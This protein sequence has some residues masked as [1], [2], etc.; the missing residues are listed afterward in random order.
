MPLRSLA[1]GIVVLIAGCSLFSGHGGATTLDGVTLIRH[2]P[3][4][5]WPAGLLRGRVEVVD[6]CVALVGKGW[7]AFVLWPDGFD[8]RKGDGELEVAG[9]VFVIPVGST[10]EGGGGLMHLGNAQSLAGDAIP[11]PCQVKGE[12][13]AY[14]GEVASVGATSDAVAMTGRSSDLSGDHALLDG[15]FAVRDRCLVIE[16]GGAIVVGRSLTTGSPDTRPRPDERRL[17]GP[18]TVCHDV[19]VMQRSYGF[20]FTYA[21]TRPA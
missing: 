20:G 11:E 1:L 16:T 14:V 3:S 8:L 15:R 18:S 13:Y 9:D 4:D 2:D 5:S 19:P 7:R 6:G 12:S 10:V 17:P 21:G